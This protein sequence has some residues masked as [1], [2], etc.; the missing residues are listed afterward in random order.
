VAFCPPSITLRGAV[1]RPLP[2]LGRVLQQPDQW[3]PEELLERRAILGTAGR[4]PVAF[5]SDP[6][7]MAIALRNKD[8]R[9]PRSRLQD[10]ILGTSYGANLL[11]G[12]REDW[13]G[14]R[15]EIARPITAERAN[16]LARRLEL[17]GSAMV[18]EWSAVPSGQPLELLRDCRRLTLDALWRAIFASEEEAQTSNSIVDATA[19][20]MA[21][22]SDLD[23]RSELAHLSGLAET[24]LQG[25]SG[26]AEAGTA[27]PGD[28][29]TLTLF[30][31]AGH[32][33]TTV[34][35]SWAVWL[36]AY[37]P[38]LQRQIA[39]EWRDAQGSAFNLKCFPIANAVVRETLRLYPPIIQ[40]MRETREDFPVEG[41]FTVPAGTT[42]VLAIYAMHR[43]R[44][45]WPDPDA[46][47]PERFLENGG[48]R[49]TLNP[50]LPFGAGPRGCIGSQLARVEMAVFLGLICDALE[51]TPNTDAPLQSKMLWSLRPVGEGP[52]FARPRA[53][54]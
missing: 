13:R 19:R 34:T 47:L 10:R 1:D 14:Q 39:R 2:T 17:A 35:M 46:F 20:A 21:A 22:H 12:E 42:L 5:I 41:E 45:F 26:F 7:A 23:L 54:A 16:R 29:N 3:W 24:I 30:L 32:D 53:R 9:F 25:G 52:V 28:R 8:D 6:T 36:L 15:N 4:Q 51:L 27:T 31:H 11:Q 50:W 18:A 40:L 37:R 38:D 33:N 48:E 44:L 49:T 43:H